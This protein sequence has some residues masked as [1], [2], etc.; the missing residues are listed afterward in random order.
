M[1][2]FTYFDKAVLSMLPLVGFKPDLIHCHDWQTGLIPVYLKTEFQAN[3][4]FWNMKSI[5]TIHNLK[6][7]GVWDVKTLQGLSGLPM[8]LFTP[9]K[10]E[11]NKT[12]NMLKGG[13]VYADY[14]TT[15]SGTYADEI[16]TPYY[17]EG[18]DGLLGSRHFDMQG[19]INGIDY[20]SYDPAKDEHFDA[21]IAGVDAQGQLMLRL[22]SGEVR[23]YWFKEVK[24]VL[25]CGVTKE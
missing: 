21:E 18:L 16:Q 3:P 10:L 24:F 15:V 2:K 17:G 12:G 4:F 20:D 22:P 13:L 8:D 6:F 11:F 25:P 7:Q 23:S 5:M 9:D 14:I 1:E 19:I